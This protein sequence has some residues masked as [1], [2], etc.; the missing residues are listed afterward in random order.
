MNSLVPEK[1][2]SLE[3]ARAR[4][5][6]I[7]NAFADVFGQPKKRNASQL[8]VIEHLGTCAGDDGNS[9]RFNEV[10]DGVALI[11]AGIHRDGA[12]SL[13]RVI[14]RQLGIAANPRDAK[15][16]KPVTTR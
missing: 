2:D 12:R 16:P 6:R 3:Q 11:A 13:L 8:L 1:N 5:M 15:K 9:Y 14:D 4:A 10:K 7:A